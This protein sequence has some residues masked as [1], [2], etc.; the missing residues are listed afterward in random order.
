LNV[1]EYNTIDLVE[2]S[3]K[4]KTNGLFLP[5][6]LKCKKKVIVLAITLVVIPI[7][8]RRWQRCIGKVSDG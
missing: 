6:S 4:R 5:P 8:S 2:E 1:G 3:K 7:E